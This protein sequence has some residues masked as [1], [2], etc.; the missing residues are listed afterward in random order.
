M[1]RRV[2]LQ[3]IPNHFSCSGCT[4]SCTQEMF[5]NHHTTIFKCCAPQPDQDK[6]ATLL[7][8]PSFVPPPERLETLRVLFS[9]QT[10]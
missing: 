3:E 5:R 7:R 10:A 6:Q 4:Q 8:K 2:S 1:P 9:E